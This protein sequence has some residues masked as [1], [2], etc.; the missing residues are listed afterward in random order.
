MVGLLRAVLTRLCD[1]S[2]VE[3][4]HPVGADAGFQSAR[5]SALGT[6]IDRR[7]AQCLGRLRTKAPFGVLRWRDVRVTSEGRAASV[8]LAAPDGNTVTLAL[9]VKGT[10]VSGGYRLER[11]VEGSVT[12]IAGAVRAAMVALQF[13]Q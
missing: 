6:G 11:P 7:L 3:V 10:G 12:E 9:T 8:T 1:G 13:S 5:G 4:L 2:G